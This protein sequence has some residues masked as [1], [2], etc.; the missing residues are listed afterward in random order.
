MKKVYLIIGAI[1]I[2]LI[3]TLLIVFGPAFAKYVSSRQGSST[4]QVA[5]PICRLE[6]V[7]S[8]TDE[9]LNSYCD[10]KVMNYDTNNRVSDVG[11]TYEIEVTS[12]DGSAAP[13][14]YWVD[15][16]VN[17][18][19]SLTAELGHTTKQSNTH[20]ICFINYGEEEVTRNVKFKVN[21]TQLYE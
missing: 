13:D 4:T 1:I 17:I 20:K 21:A 15:N 2:V 5:K 8:S 7:N 3:V 9:Q 6:V 16:G 18:G 14:Y 10:V 11:M 19:T 12:S